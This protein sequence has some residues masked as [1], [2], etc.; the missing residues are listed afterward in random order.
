MQQYVAIKKQHPDSLLFYRLGDFFELFFDDAVTASRELDI[1]LTTRCKQ[2]G[3][4][5]PM[6]G[7][8]V[9]A[10]ELYLAKLIQ[11]GYRVVICDQ[12]ETP[13]EAKSRGAKGPLAREITR[14]VTSGTVTEEGLLPGGNNYIIAVYSAKGQV[15]I[16]IADISTG[17]FGLEETANLSEAIARWSPSEIIVSDG[18]FAEMQEIFEPWAK[19]LTILPD[20]KYKSLDTE[21][22]LASVYNVQTL[23]IFGNI[24]QNALQ[25]AGLLVDYVISTQ[26]C[27]NLSLAAPQMIHSKD[28]LSIDMATRRNLELI[29]AENKSSS[30]FATL[31]NTKTA[32]GRRLLLKW[33]SAP[34]LDIQKIEV[35]LDDID[36]FVKDAP[37]RKHIRDCLQGL[38]DIERILSRVTLKRV[39]PRDMGALRLAL[40]RVRAIK[41]AEILN[42][43][44]LLSNVA[45][46]E[47]LLTEL[48]HAFKEDLPLQARDGDFIAEG[49]DAQLDEF[50]DLRDHVSDNL[51]KLQDQ[52]IQQTGIHNIRIR[53]NS[54]WGIYIE[55]SA[56]QVSKVPFDFIHKQTLTNCTRYTTSELMELEQ[57]IEKAETSYINREIEI[58]EA[59]SARILGMRGEFMDMSKELAYMDVV[60]S[61][62]ELAVVNK[63]V[64]P[65][66]STKPEL[67][68]VAGRHPVVEQSFKNKEEYFA[69]NDCVLN[70]ESRRF[71]LM[72][73]PNMAGKSTYLRQ[74]ALIV[75]MAQMG[76]FVPADKAIIGIVDKIFSRI[77]ASDDLASGRS[78][79]MV[80][81]IETAAILH[82]AT[83]QS[84]V[85]LD[86]IGRGTATYDGLSIAWSVSE[87]LY[88]AV[89][90]RTMFATHYH[91]L[92]KLSEAFG[93]VV[94]VTAAT[95]EW[96]DKI[97]FLHKIVDGC[98]HKSYGIHVAQIAG[99]PKKVII[100]A[101]ELLQAFETEVNVR[102]KNEKVIRQH[103]S[104]LQK[105]LF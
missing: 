47:E 56:S 63:Y 82:Q 41:L 31:N 42:D 85:I 103:I 24:P 35:R 12:I 30:L 90:C 21:H 37:L 99:L 15:A 74:N 6:C 13:E 96:E 45:D 29:T 101:T 52:Y 51:Q 33:I 22:L 88:Q 16:A 61:G 40:G 81:M 20:A 79:F 55:V 93:G 64:R 1:V 102:P 73:G 19:K 75:I 14:I 26:C 17:F 54:V 72:T 70:F 44:K 28:F 60:T 53:R 78:T 84:L 4:D 65:H 86:E 67:S 43:R 66:F 8:P 76:F 68:I 18:I 11:K 23:D 46:F 98:A 80:E 69:A 100:R 7:V 57:R 49:F 105:E 104:K 95:R 32:A 94:P 59:F 77:G 34:L 62:A 25:A 58:F 5:V 91:E 9:H 3:K 71:L 39:S 36:F 2:G 97:I 89:Q 27:R 50:R 10:Y 92:T 87:Y 48:E 83:G 38:P